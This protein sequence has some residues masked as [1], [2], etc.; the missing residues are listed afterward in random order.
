MAVRFLSVI[1]I[2][3]GTKAGTESGVGFGD[4]TD[5]EDIYNRYLLLLSR[6]EGEMS[7]R[8]LLLNESQ[9][10]NEAIQHQYYPFENL[11]KPLKLDES[12]LYRTILLLENIH[13]PAMVEPL[14]PLNDLMIAFRRE[15]ENVEA[16]VRYRTDVYTAESIRLLAD[17]FGQVLAQALDHVDTKLKEFRFH[18]PETV[19]KRWETFNRTEQA[20]PKQATVHGL[21]EQQVQLTPEAPA[22]ESGSQTVSYRELNERAERVAQ[23]LRLCGAG[24]GRRVGIMAGHGPGLLAGIL[25]VLKSG[26]SYVPVDPDYPLERIRY[27]AEDSGLCAWVVEP[28]LEG[29]VPKEQVQGVVVVDDRGRAELLTDSGEAAV[30]A[31]A[32]VTAVEAEVAAAPETLIEGAAEVTTGAGKETAPE[33]PSEVTSEAGPEGT[34]EAEDEA[35]VIYTSGSTG[36]PKGVMVCHRNVV[37]YLWWARKMYLKGLDSVSMALYSSIAFDLTVTSLFLPLIAGGCVVAYRSEHRGQAL[38]R[39]LEEDRVDVLKLTPTHLRLLAEEAVARP[40]RLKRLIVGGESLDS[41]LARR[42]SERFGHEVEIYNEYGPTEATVGCMIHRYAPEKDTEG[43]VPIGIPADNVQ[44]YVL[45][46]YGHPTPTGVI[47]EIYIGGEGVAVGYVGNPELTAERFV[48]NRHGGG[49]L[50]R[51]GDLGRRLPDGTLQYVGR[52]DEQVKVRGH[53]IELGEIELELQ[54]HE[55]VKAAAVVARPDE[56]GE[57]E[58]WAYVQVNGTGL[59]EELKRYL[60]ERLPEYMIPAY[61]EEREQLPV[62]SNGKIDRKALLEEE[63]SQ[64]TPYVAPR[65]ELEQR[66]VQLWEE[67]LGRDRIGIEDDFFKI[68]GHSLKA[69]MMLARV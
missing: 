30:E 59:S 6:L 49:R 63:G 55:A 26:A 17:R 47:G 37:N 13:D 18:E 10:V 64:R 50:Y 5:E 56:G 40:R 14:L 25:G 32:A 44:I 7:F 58:L 52:R 45:D 65:N 68:G 9:T 15:G 67:V 4:E 51:T 42:V 28:G 39:V 11:I 2:H 41:G 29:S 19:R 38:M 1:D 22:V 21:F 36:R 57:L 53:R 3:A 43:S 62:T 66:L 33:A 60:S 34:A 54:G 31:A 20:Y 46:P 69:I 8:E 24:R 48:P 23:L 16:T 27:M 35:Y 12:R 61:I